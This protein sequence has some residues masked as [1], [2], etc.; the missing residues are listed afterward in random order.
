MA[1]DTRR[2]GLS[3][4]II[5]VVGILFFWLTDPRYG[6]LWP[7][8]RAATVVDAIRQATPGTLIGMAGSAL[9]LLIGLWLMTR[10]VS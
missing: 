8:Q 3:L 1:R 7:G 4:I 5:G 2:S 9:V 6:W 10:R